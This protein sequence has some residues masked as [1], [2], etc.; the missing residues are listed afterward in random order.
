MYSTNTT[1]TTDDVRAWFAY[2][3]PRDVAITDS[4]RVLALQGMQLIYGW[5]QYFFSGALWERLLEWTR[6]TRGRVYFGGNNND[7]L[8]LMERRRNQTAEPLPE[9][10]FVPILPGSVVVP[11]LQQPQNNK[12]RSARHAQI[13]TIPLEAT[14]LRQEDYPASWMVYHRV[15]GVVK[16]TEAD[17][18][19]Q[20]M[21]EAL[22]E[23]VPD[24]AGECINEE[25]GKEE[26]EKKEEGKSSEIDDEKTVHHSNVSIRRKTGAS[27]GLDDSS[28]SSDNNNNNKD[29]SA[30]FPVLHSIAASG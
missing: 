2:Y 4:L 20:K 25:K 6:R 26:E 10:E 3:F 8:Q 29:N 15:L 11:D 17:E 14:F 5:L 23:N 16:K 18:Y 12:S 1:V 21:E 7:N 22:E 13:N 24:G 27:P 28:S 19:D 9:L 30:V